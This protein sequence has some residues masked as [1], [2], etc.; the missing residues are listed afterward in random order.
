MGSVAAAA[1]AEKEAAAFATNRGE[2]ARIF[3]RRSVGSRETKKSDGAGE[4]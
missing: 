1:T 3:L 4:S 2:K